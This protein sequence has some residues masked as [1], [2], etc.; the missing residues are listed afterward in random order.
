MEQRQAVPI[1]DTVCFNL[2][3][4]ARQPERLI[5]WLSMHRISSNRDEL[6]EFLLPHPVTTKF[7]T[8][9]LVESENY[10]QVDGDNEHPNP[11]VDVGAILFSGT[12]LNF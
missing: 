6:L 8:A 9:V 4:Q 2:A 1:A 3:A 11:N 7:V 5:C 12:T 10:L